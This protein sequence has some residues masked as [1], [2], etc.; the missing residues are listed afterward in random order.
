MKILDTIGADKITITNFDIISIDTDKFKRLV[1]KEYIIL[2]DPEEGRNI[3]DNRTSLPISLVNLRFPKVPKD[4]ENDNFL[5]NFLFTGFKNG[6][7]SSLRL[8]LPKVL[9]GNNILNITN[10]ECFM[11]CLDKAKEKLFND[12][13]IE[14][15]FNNAHFKEIEINKTLTLDKPFNEYKQAL[16]FIHNCIKF[17]QTTRRGLYHIGDNFSGI[18]FKNKEMQLKF[19]DKAL[20]QGIEELGNNMLRVELTLITNQKILNSLGISSVEE[21]KDN[22]YVLEDYFNK[23]TERFVKQPTLKGIEEHRK[24]IAKELKEQQKAN[25]RGFWQKAI[26]RIGEIYDFEMFKEEVCKCISKVN[27]ARTCKTLDKFKDDILKDN[28]K[29]VCLGNSD[30]F[31]NVLELINK[32]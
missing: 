4:K 7:E 32:L 27:K 20:E 30:A 17:K 23:F 6:M 10:G 8:N 16:G 21:L 12:Y 14:I 25:S 1:G 9:H 3:F 2:G 31:T 28:K 19:Y 29:N 26:I 18:D 15:N 22:Y 13:G 5:L 24:F 11:E